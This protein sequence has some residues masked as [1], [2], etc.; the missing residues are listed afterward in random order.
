MNSNQLDAAVAKALGW[1]LEADKWCDSDRQFKGHCPDF[2]PSTNWLQAGKLIEEYKIDLNYIPDSPRTGKSDIWVAD[3]WHKNPN[4]LE[5][6]GV[7]PLIAVCRAIVAALTA[8][9]D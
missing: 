8:K 5:G 6:E 3:P 7:T 2:S 9:E 1:H 4:G